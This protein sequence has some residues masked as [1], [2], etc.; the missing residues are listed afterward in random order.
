M[1]VSLR[2]L[3]M[4]PAW[5]ISSNNADVNFDADVQK[6]EEL[7]V[8]PIP[9]ATRRKLQSMGFTPIIHSAAAISTGNEEA[10]ENYPNFDS[11]C[12]TVLTNSMLN[13]R[14]VEEHSVPIMQV[15]SGVQMHSKLKCY[16]TFYCEARDGNIQA[17]ESDA[18]TVS[19]V[20][21]D[22]IG[23]RAISNGLNF[24]VILDKDL[25]VCGIYPCFINGKLCCVEQL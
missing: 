5:S 9:D 23:E 22:L 3:S 10:E 12:S 19:S 11:A 2:Y 17:V 25:N 14:Q 18:L 16:K 4:R 7:L 24:Q 6:R 15:E 20:K 8:Q 21:Q 13:C 1:N